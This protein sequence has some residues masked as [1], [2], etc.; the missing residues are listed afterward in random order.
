[1]ILEQIAFPAHELRALDGNGGSMK[2]RGRGVPYNEWSEDVGGFRERFAPGSLRQTLADEDIRAIYNHES[3]Q[4]IGRKSSGTARFT[5]EEDGVWYEADPPD[6][7]WARDMLVSIRRGDVRENSF[8]FW[9][10]RREDQAWE[11]R[12]GIM[13]RTIHRARLREMGPQTFPAYPSSSVQVRSA[14]AVLSEGRAILE[15]AKASG[16][17][18]TL[19]MLGEMEDLGRKMGWGGP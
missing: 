18:D 6:A 4:I 2:L 1:M 16:D 17:P 7:S 8:Q 12:D 10:E 19:R 9:V 3:S 13:W 11:E 15:A 5:E 14:D